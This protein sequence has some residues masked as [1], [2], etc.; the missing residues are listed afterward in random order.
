[1]RLKLKIKTQAL[2]VRGS[3]Q[4]YDPATGD[5]SVKLDIKL[6]GV[7]QNEEGEKEAID[8]IHFR[9]APDGGI[10]DQV[11]NAEWEILN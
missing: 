3:L 10:F 7:A 9:Q 5:F 4:T 2:P 8:L 11:W 1:M 6:L